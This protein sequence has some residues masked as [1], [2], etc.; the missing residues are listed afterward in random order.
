MEA[1]WEYHVGPMDLLENATQQKQEKLQNKMLSAIIR[2][3]NL[4]I[5]LIDT[6]PDIKISA[7]KK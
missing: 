1:Q 6:S 3:Q 5:H 4:A 7:F 2:L